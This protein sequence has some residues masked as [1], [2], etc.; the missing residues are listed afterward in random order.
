MRH[1][2]AMWKPVVIAAACLSSCA[3]TGSS[4]E[5]SVA[6]DPPGA[7]VLVDGIDSGFV[8]PCRMRLE[9]GEARLVELQ[10]PGYKPEQRQLVPERDV[11]LAFW[12]E[13][14]IREQV[15]RFPLWLNLQDFVSPV[16]AP[17]VLVPGRVYVQLDR[18]RSAP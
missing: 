14:Y 16:Q 6:S 17:T 3:L 5:V 8:T 7:R 2:S 10:L 9:A 12:R 11:E 1:P 15:W 4:A 13:S 18:D